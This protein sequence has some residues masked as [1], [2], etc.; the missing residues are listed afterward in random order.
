MASPPDVILVLSP[1]MAQ[2]LREAAYIKGWDL[3]AEKLG[4]DSEDELI[5][6]FEAMRAEIAEQLSRDHV[7]TNVV[8]NLPS[9]GSLDVARVADKMAK[10]ARGAVEG[11]VIAETDRAFQ[12]PS[13]DAE[14]Q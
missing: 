12:L 7:R 9:D 5:L 13:P 3:D 14:V 2:A 11:D 8:L 6:A 1:R 10:A 4:F